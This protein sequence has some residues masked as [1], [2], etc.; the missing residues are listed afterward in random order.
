MGQH[1]EMMM[2]R[3]DAHGCYLG[4]ILPAYGFRVVVPDPGDRSRSAMA[5][6]S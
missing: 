5:L 4:Q 1:A 6:I 2:Q 3:R